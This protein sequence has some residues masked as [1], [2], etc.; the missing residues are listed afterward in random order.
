[1]KM[2]L[3]RSNKLRSGEHLSRAGF[4]PSAMALAI[5]SVGSALLPAEIGPSTGGTNVI[6]EVIV[7]ARK[8]EE[9]LQETPVV[10]NV[11]T[12][13]MLNSQRIEGIEDL[14][15]IVPGL[16]TSRS[17]ASSAGAIYLRGVGT[18]SGNGL[19]D[20]AVAI[21]FDGVG[22]SSPQLIMT[23][24]MFDLDRIE[25]LR[26]PQALFYGKN[27]PG[28]VIALHTKKPTDEFE[29]ELTAM[30]ETEGEEPAFRG[31][32]S[33]A[34]SETLFGRLSVGW[35][36]ADNHLFDVVNFDVFEPGPGGVPVQ[37]A[38]GTSKH[39]VEI[40]RVYAMG[41]LLWE[42]TDSFSASL[43]Y[44]LFGRESGWQRCLQLPAYPVW[45]R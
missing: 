1:M 8:R 30:Y 37:T 13:D 2:K 43:K 17:G 38:F 21:N 12:S 42:P 45:A 28:G 16:V 4:N 10:V 18:G 24:G 27:S 32:V 23:A 26:G 20:Q 6:E 3:S 39:P 44:A 41:T 19:F 9:S 22:I 14:G 11:L 34:F 5:M 29:M 7:T 33:G 25:V 35:S 31:I 40:E 36:E 15:S